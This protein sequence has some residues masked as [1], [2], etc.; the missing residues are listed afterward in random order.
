[1]EPIR[2]VW[3]A[4]DGPTEHSSYD[5]ALAAAGVH[6]YNLVPV[7]SVIPAGAEVEAVG[8]AP[9]LGPAGDRL[10]VVQARAT[11]T[12]P[13]HVSAGLAWSQSADGPGLF[14]EAAG[15]F[16]PDDVRE[17]I[18]TGLAAGERL[19]EWS[20]GDHDEWVESAEADPGAYSTAVVLAVYGES[21][22]ML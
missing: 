3:G 6:N 18:R 11:A 12:G 1:M 2:V 22:P 5:A 8:T 21:E 20:F 10:H 16:D 9:D 7:S 14:Y 13:G 4:A 15:E 17:R 19:R